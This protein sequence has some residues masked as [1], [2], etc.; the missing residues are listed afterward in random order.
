MDQFEFF[1]E[2]S[3]FLVITDLGFLELKLSENKIKYMHMIGVEEKMFSYNKNT[4]L[5]LAV[6]DQ[7][8]IKIWFYEVRKF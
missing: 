5:L 8:E 7:N 3:M 2:K 1:H 4:D 6:T